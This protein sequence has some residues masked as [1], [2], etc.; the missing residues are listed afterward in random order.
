MVMDN[1]ELMSRITGATLPP[2]LR[3]A[4]AR[5]SSGGTRAIRHAIE[6]AWNRGALDALDEASARTFARWM[7]SRQTA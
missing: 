7:I 1:P 2:V 4:S 5:R 3:T 6:V